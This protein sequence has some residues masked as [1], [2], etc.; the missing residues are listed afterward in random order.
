MEDFLSFEI[1]KRLKDKG[2]DWV[3]ITTYDPKTKVRNNHL[4][5]TISQV[6]KWLREEKLILIGISPMQ[7]YD[8][9][10]T[11]EWCSGVY[12]ADKQGTL[13]LEEEFY[14]E[15]YEK[16]ANAGIKYILDNLI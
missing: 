16:A 14:C 13:R 1:A 4:E 2:F 8:V 7:E 3:K 12:K 11:I 5:P 10:E 9:E 15:T 6:F